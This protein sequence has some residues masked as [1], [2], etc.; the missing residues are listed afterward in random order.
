[1][2]HLPNLLGHPSRYVWVVSGH[3]FSVQRCWSWMSGFD[4]S[5][6]FLPAE[7]T[8]QDTLQ[9]P[10]SVMEE[11]Q[12]LILRSINPNIKILKCNIGVIFR[13]FRLMTVVFVSLFLSSPKAPRAPLAPCPCFFLGGRTR[14]KRHGHTEGDRR[15][16]PRRCQPSGKP[17]GLEEPENRSAFQKGKLSTSTRWAPKNPVINGVSYDSDSD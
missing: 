8:Q 7:I 6:W 11:L 10:W 1:M 15:D 16:E 9:H 14:Q 12:L 3:T 5:P 17:K 2:T 13:V 4:M